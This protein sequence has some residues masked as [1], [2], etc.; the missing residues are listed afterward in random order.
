M[1]RMQKLGSISISNCCVNYNL[2][3]KPCLTQSLLLS[4]QANAWLICAWLWRRHYHSVNPRLTLQ[5]S[6]NYSP[7]WKAVS[8]SWLSASVER[9]LINCVDSLRSYTQRIVISSSHFTPG[10]TRNYYFGARC[11]RETCKLRAFNRRAR[12]RFWFIKCWSVRTYISSSVRSHAWKDHLSTSCLQRNY[13]EMILLNW[14]AD[15]FKK[16][17]NFMK[18]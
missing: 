17:K 2:D 9:W 3:E 7:F 1:K 6:R 10:W 11:C 8:D 18:E 4:Q 14:S 5:K 16:F 13:F 12:N 15:K